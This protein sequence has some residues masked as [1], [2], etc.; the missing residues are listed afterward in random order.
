MRLFA[1]V[2]AVLLLA[3]CGG[4]T[5]G[6]GTLPSLP[7]SSSSATTTDTGTTTDGGTT[8]STTTDETETDDAPIETT[9]TQTVTET[10]TEAAPATTE[11]APAPDPLADR[12]PA[13]AGLV[14]RGDL[15]S[16]LGFK[17]ITLP[18]SPSRC[19]TAPVRKVDPAGSVSGRQF[20]GNRSQSV[21]S[22]L[23]WSFPDSDAASEALA[24]V[25]TTEAI[26]CFGKQTARGSA[27]KAQVPGRGYARLPHGRR[28]DGR[29]PRRLP[30][31]GRQRPRR[32]HLRPH[33]PGA[34]RGR[35]PELRQRSQAVDRQGGAGADRRA[36]PRRRVTRPEP[37]IDVKVPGQ[38]PRRR[39]HPR[40][41][42]RWAAVL[43]PGRR[44]R[45]APP[46]PRPEAS[47]ADGE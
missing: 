20:V 18:T 21:V 38:R 36:R 35:V 12:R 9:V 15:P 10:E 6:G 44:R 27:P 34:D 16:G 8:E 43:A 28:R 4:G 19:F 37:P 45:P 2:A 22:S 33:R 41:S 11:A 42:E 13:R 7:G 39:Q 40:A 3:A 24:A 46:D 32:L 26:D 31:G 25:A 17:G 5:G 23:A 47:P 29:V 30:A 14:T 1:A